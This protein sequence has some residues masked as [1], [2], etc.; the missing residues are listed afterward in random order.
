MLGT[1]AGQRNGHALSDHEEDNG[2]ILSLI[3]SKSA[4][5]HD[6][7]EV[8]SLSCLVFGDSTPSRTSLVDLHSLSSLLGPLTWLAKFR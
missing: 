1:K 5:F 7:P 8:R 2:L 6:Y 3:F 4:R